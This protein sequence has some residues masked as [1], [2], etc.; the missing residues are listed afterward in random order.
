MIP[1]PNP[2]QHLQ[3]WLGLAF[4]AV[5]GTTFL[6]C[7]GQDGDLGRDFRTLASHA[8]Q[9]KCEGDSCPWRDST[10]IRSDLQPSLESALAIADSQ[11]GCKYG[12]VGYEQN[13]AEWQ[14][15]VLGLGCKGGGSVSHAMGSSSLQ[16]CLTNDSKHLLRR[17]KSSRGNSAPHSIWYY[18]E[19]VGHEI[20]WRPYLGDAIQECPD[21]C[22]GDSS[23]ILIDS[24]RGKMEVVSRTI[25]PVVTLDECR[26]EKGFFSH[27]ISPFVAGY[28]AVR[29]FM[30]PKDA[31]I[32]W[33]ATS[34]MLD[35]TEICPLIVNP[36]TGLTDYPDSVWEG[37]GL[38]PL[39]D[40][41]KSRFPDTGVQLR[42][43]VPL[44]LPYSA[45]NP[46]LRSALRSGFYQVS[47]ESTPDSSI[48]VIILDEDDIES[49]PPR[50][51]RP[52]LKYLELKTDSII[53]FTHPFDFWNRF[54]VLD[55]LENPSPLLDS[56][57]N[58][59]PQAASLSSSKEDFRDDRPD[60]LWGIRR[61]YPIAQLTQ[62]AK[63]REMIQDWLLPLDQT[64]KATI[65]VDPSVRFGK[66][67][68]ILWA[69][70]HT[71]TDLPIKIR[72]CYP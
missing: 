14:R 41:L 35:G 44:D 66:I 43:R 3:A 17:K 11:L 50:P 68:T 62:P 8:G 16:F 2:R 55:L 60:T 1:R 40:A 24:S 51:F 59:S 20:R 72:A 63:V 69:I 4:A 15:I 13:G 38:S 61:A 5:V 34:L 67:Q 36:R 54:D 10:W 27:L 53:T 70:R 56:L 22:H 19:E 28:A 18:F 21:E 49:D 29:Q 6:S 64:R 9:V 45:L 31:T 65:T 52:G 47:L 7:S 39:N 71:G 33:S 32:E 25:H 57:L 48:R 46:V 12:V 58:A 30:A 42:L 23:E 37:F 26:G